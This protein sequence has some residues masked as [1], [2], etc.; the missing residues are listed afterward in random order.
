MLENRVV[1][2]CIRKRLET[3]VWAEHEIETDPENE[4]D[5]TSVKYTLVY[6]TPPPPTEDLEMEEEGEIEE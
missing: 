2:K 5:Y 3:V 6:G 1:R 4:E